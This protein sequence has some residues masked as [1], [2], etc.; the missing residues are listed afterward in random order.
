MIFQ[1]INELTATQG[2]RNCNTCFPL[3]PPGLLHMAFDCVLRLC[4]QCSGYFLGAILNIPTFLSL[5]AVLIETSCCFEMHLCDSLK[6]T[7]QEKVNTNSKGSCECLPWKVIY[8]S[9][10]YLHSCIYIP[11]MCIYAI[12]L[13][14]Q[15]DF[16]ALVNF[17]WF[18]SD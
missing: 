15:A 1:M 8:C 12:Q 16:L 4:D 9:G 3:A 17:Q 18:I 11:S 10:M 6:G 13:Y 7:L 14:T 5:M 2:R